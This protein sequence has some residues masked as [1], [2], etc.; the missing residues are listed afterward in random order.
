[1]LEVGPGNAL[2]SL[3]R[4]TLGR[5]ASVRAIA[6][7]PHPKEAR[8]DLETLLG[9]VGR[10]WALGATVD[11]EGFHAGEQLGRI[12]LPTYPFDRK[13]HWV[14]PRRGIAQA[15]ASSPQ[16]AEPQS[17][18]AI[19]AAERRATLDEWFHTESWLRVPLAA[20]SARL[21]D[22]TWLVFGGR[23]ALTSEVHDRF[24]AAGATVIVV[25][26]GERYERTAD[27][28]YAVRPL[29]RA[30]YDALLR[31]LQH[32]GVRL[33]GVVHLWSTDGES[34]GTAHARDPF[35]SLVALGGALELGAAT[36]RLRLIVAT[37]DAQSVTGERITR[38]E[39]SMLAGVTLVLPEERAGV[40]ARL[41]DLDDVDGA[42]GVSRAARQLLD[43]ARANDGE[44]V[45]ARRADKRWVR[46]Y[47]ATE[48]AAGLAPAL[49]L[50]DGGVYLITGGLGGIGL[51]VS[52][53]LARET[54]A[55]LL[56]TSRSALPARDTWDSWL[57]EHDAADE[58]ARR[59]AAVRRIESAGGE[60]RI[61][62]A[63]AADRTAMSAALEAAE[64][65]WGEV[66]G[67]IH[68]A[69]VPD[70]EA[71]ASATVSSTN[72]LLEAKVGGLNVLVDLLG[73]RSLDLVVLVSSINAVVGNAGTAAYTAA[74]AY[75]D[76]FAQ[77]SHA[78]P[79]WKVSS[80][81]FDAWS[82]IGMAT[83][84]VVPAG[85]RE[86]RKAYVA[87]GIPPR[88]G[89][90]AISRMLMS[91]LPT[92]VVSPFDVE[93]TLGRRR[94]AA[95]AMHAK[96]LVATK[97]EPAGDQRPT[98]SYDAD[99]SVEA[100]LT[101]MWSDLLGVEAIGL[102]DNFFELGGHS[103]LATRV[104]ARVFDQFGVQVPLR[105]LFEAPT[106]RQFAAVV[107]SLVE[108]AEV[109][110]EGDREEIEL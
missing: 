60:V 57:A 83:K 51:T 84:V 102:D 55:R 59:I 62:V 103:L 49:P 32:R 86:W 58:T 93:R 74:N 67:V 36:D 100:L 82:D 19:I 33:S 29:E 107:A 64:S 22:A 35:H 41:V 89:A 53:W 50:R 26:R 95:A 16:N 6:S 43:E 4:L 110:A 17:P 45:V 96:P 40:T 65:D 104:L 39:L 25:E 3:A 11:W 30:D 92:V 109:A 1:M 71:L 90:Q 98:S 54:S 56:L 38:P 20:S 12:P 23:T 15:V 94:D 47:V 97:G 34:G 10:L 44:G 63:D 52:E 81:A 68:A 77:S 13:R 7:L 69:G 106:I 72:A 37:R 61:A 31:E 9:A 28:R 66:A 108:P 78:P 27:Q 18:A 88:E 99:A 46:R 91:E 101:A 87:A 24:A 76:A 80:I 85:M 14:E 21:D 2:T 42:S 8:G 5:E 73:E 48:V 70:A 105:T 75:F 79:S